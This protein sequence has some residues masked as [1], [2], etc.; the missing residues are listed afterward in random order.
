MEQPADP[1]ETK[2]KEERLVVI[3]D[4]LIELNQNLKEVF[5]QERIC[6]LKNDI[7]GLK[8]V[9]GQEMAI[10][11][12]LKENE[13]LRVGV[14]EEFRTAYSIE[15]DP[16]HIQDLLKVVPESFRLRFE[17]QAKSLKDILLSLMHVRNT[18]NRVIERMLRFNEKNIKLFLTAGKTDLS[19]DQNGKMSQSNK[20]V[21]NS[22]V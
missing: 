17:Q 10:G 13:Q 8:N 9:N 19:Y 14:L 20:Q 22:I 16:I 3:L 11:S 6:L 7:F 21:L 2:S 12:E 4:R 1:S 18:N 15:A 5:E